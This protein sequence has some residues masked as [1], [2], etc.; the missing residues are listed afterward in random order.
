MLHAEV[1]ID[2]LAEFVFQANKSDAVIELG[3]NGLVDA[4]DLFFFCVDLMIK[5]LVMLY[6]VDGRVPIETVTLEQFEHVAMKM[7]N[8][9]LH[10]HLHITEKPEGMKPSVKMPDESVSNHL[11]LEKY[12]LYI[13]SYADTY[14]INFTVSHFTNKEI[15]V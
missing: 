9:H 13:H 10:P 7:G 4:K 2:L 5:G 15:C 12:Y 8:A 14:H 11:P 6:A 1:G 3:L